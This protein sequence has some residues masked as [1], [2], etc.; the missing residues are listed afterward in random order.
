MNISHLICL[1]HFTA[2]IRFV[3]VKLPTIV[4]HLLQTAWCFRRDYRL[5]VSGCTVFVIPLW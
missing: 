1:R 4:N 3:L 5:F 2:I